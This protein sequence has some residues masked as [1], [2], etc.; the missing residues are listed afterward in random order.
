M[1]CCGWLA[2]LVLV[3]SRRFWW[4]KLLL[5]LYGQRRLWRR[6]HAPDR[7]GS[8]R[9]RFCAGVGQRHAVGAPCLLRPC[10]HIA[11][12]FYRPCRPALELRECLVDMRRLRKVASL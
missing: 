8:R 6:G 1:S 10:R 11:Y 3:R 12:L 4:E 9:Q 2:G 5:S 7:G